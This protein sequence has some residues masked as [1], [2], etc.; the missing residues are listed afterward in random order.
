VFVC[1]VALVGG[2]TVAGVLPVQ[3]H[4]QPVPLYLGDDAGRSDG[5][6]T[7]VRFGQAALGERE[8]GKREVV[9]EQR[10][11]LPRQLGDGARHRL[12]SRC[13]NP[14]GIH[15]RRLR[16][17]DPYPQSDL[18]DAGIDGLPLGRGKLL[19]VPHVG[20]NGEQ[21]GA[22]WR[23]DDRRRT[24]GTRPRPAPGLVQTGDPEVTYGP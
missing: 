24:Y 22:V 21:V 6:T 1:T 2:E 5:E 20:Q 3:G 17:A 15:L 23:K 18:P 8:I 19:G 11:H 9:D 12:P 4:H 16:P 13:Q 14:Q 10:V 7:G